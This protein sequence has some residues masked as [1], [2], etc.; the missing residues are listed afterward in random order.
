MNKSKK[1][2]RPCEQCGKIMY[3]IPSRLKQRFCNRECKA[4]FQKGSKLSEETKAKISAKVAGKN[5]PNYGNKWTDEQKEKFSEKRKSLITDELRHAYGNANRGKAFSEERKRNMSEAQRGKTKPPM[6]EETKAKIGKSSAERH[7][8]EGYTDNITKKRNVTRIANGTMVDPER[9]P[10][11]KVYWKEANWLKINMWELAI[12]GQVLLKEIGVFNPKTN[13]KGVVRD[14]IVSRTKGFNAGLFPEI[15]RHPCNCQIITISENSSR[16]YIIE[17]IEDI[18]EK[19]FDRIE[20]YDKIWD[21]QE[22][23]MK[24]IT[25][26]KEGQRWQR[27]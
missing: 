3:L 22:L 10:D 9:L 26:Y 7:K 20:N 4:N 12:T 1:V 13:S 23:V 16:Q 18:I 25:Q 5:N 15:L 14:H 24:L 8:V 6:T 2:E 17:N 19:L 27:K 11:Y 21:E